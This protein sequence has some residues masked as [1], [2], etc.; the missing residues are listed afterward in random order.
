[1]HF[2]RKGKLALSDGRYFG[3]GFEAYARLNFATSRAILDQVLD[4]MA[5][6]LES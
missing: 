1:M 4:R 3:A 5:T 6:A 2:I